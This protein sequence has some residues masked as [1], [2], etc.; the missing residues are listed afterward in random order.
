MLGNELLRVLKGM[1]IGKNEI[2]FNVFS[3]SSEQFNQLRSL[4]AFLLNQN[5][6]DKHRNTI[7]LNFQP[8][9]Q[10]FFA[11]SVQKANSSSDS[12][13]TIQILPKLSDLDSNG[14]W[15]ERYFQQTLETIKK[16]ISDETRPTSLILN[17]LERAISCLSKKNLFILINLFK[18]KDLK[19]LSNLKKS[20]FFN[21]TNRK[22]QYFL[23][24][25]PIR[26][27]YLQLFNKFNFADASS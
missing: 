18:H 24:I 7:F 2:K 1:N 5:N 23:V 27:F 12:S 17:G 11:E 8:R 4:E 22:C 10:G 26:Y 6:N 13:K 9:L 15:T 20:I 3:A 14:F 25:R 16:N 19:N 21:K